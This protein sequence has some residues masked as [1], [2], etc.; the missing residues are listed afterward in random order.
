MLTKG[1]QTQKVTYLHDSVYMTGRGKIKGSENGLMMAGAEGGGGVDCKSA[2]EGA[3]TI[4][5]L[6][7]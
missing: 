3:R 5:A 2:V 7:W 6:S 4:L 1:S